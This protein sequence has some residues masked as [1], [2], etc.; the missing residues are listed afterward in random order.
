[1][2]QINSNLSTR[3]WETNAMFPIEE[4]HFGYTKDE[5]CTTVLQFLDFV[6]DI[7]QNVRMK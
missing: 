1:M 3:E 5:S 2:I 7:I 4:T 6:E